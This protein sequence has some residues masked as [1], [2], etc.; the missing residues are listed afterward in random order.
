MLKT[1]SFAI[2]ILYTL[3]LATICLVQVNEVVS[4]VSIPFGD[5]LF[6]F[7]AYILL[8][9]LWYNT[10]L[11]RFHKSK[12]R[13]LWNAI[14]FSIIFGI[15]IEILQ[16]VFTTYR[17]SDIN[18]VFANTTGVLLAAVVIGVKNKYILK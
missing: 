4:K 6:H 18:D 1:Y 7:S 10:F 17:S 9:V 8:T 16:G 2:T 11:Y 13:A 3:A 5:K 12:K 14:I 15:I